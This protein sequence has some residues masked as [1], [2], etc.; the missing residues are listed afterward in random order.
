MTTALTGLT[1]SLALSCAPNV[2]PDTIARIVQVESGNK[3]FAINVNRL[4]GRQPRADNIEDAARLVRLYIARGHTVDMGLMQINSVNL[5]RLGYTV[6]DMFDPCTNLK[7][8]AKILTENYTAASRQMDNSQA[9][10]RAALSAYN[11]GNFRNGFRNGYVAKYLRGPA[12]IDLPDGPASAPAPAIDLTA[13]KVEAEDNGPPPVV[14]NY[15]LTATYAE[16]FH[17]LGQPADPRDAGTAVLGNW[18]KRK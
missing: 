5:R 3:V 10:L 4:R 6:E 8:G 18:S 14:L 1:L 17:G 15:D 12:T 11:T 13:L 16:D 9:A 2:A 7:A